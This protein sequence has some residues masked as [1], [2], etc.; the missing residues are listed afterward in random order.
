MFSVLLILNTFP[1]YT[2]KAAITNC[3]DLN[4]EEARKGYIITVL[5]EQIGKPTDLKYQENNDKNGVIN[6]FKTNKQCAANQSSCDQYTDAACTD[7]QC[8]RVQVL[9][10]KSG[11]GLLYEY[12]H[13]I[14]VWAASVIGIVSVLFLTV[15]GIEMTA[16]QG[17]SGKMEKAKERIMNSLVG[18]VLL[19]LS[20]LILYTVN[21]NFFV[22]AGSA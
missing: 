18:L 20:A 4:K 22:I 13:L 16:S 9:F 21:P 8:S 2:A 6:C 17:D 1:I 14:Y 10:A 15:G 7:G 11:A 5:E 3:A 12:I 19:F